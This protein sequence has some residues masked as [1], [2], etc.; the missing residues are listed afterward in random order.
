MKHGLRHT[1]ADCFCDLPDSAVIYDL[2]LCKEFLICK[3]CEIVGHQ[4][5]YVLLQ[6]TDCFH[7]GTFEVMADTH[8]LTGRFHLSSKSS[9]CSDKFIE[10]KS[11]DFNYAVVKHW[12]ETCICFSCDCIRDL[13]QCVTQSDL[14][15]NFCDRVT[16]CLTCK[17][18][19]TAYTWVNL[20]NAVF[21]AVRFQSVLNVTSAC[22]S[23]LCDD[24]QG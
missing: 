1:A 6:R 24:V 5:V 13:I 20:D 12:L 7:Q 9:L 11:W 21:K 15:C 4:A 14:C 3:L 17:C 19:G 10:W 22:D 8:N 18:R 16:S 2:Q 23:K